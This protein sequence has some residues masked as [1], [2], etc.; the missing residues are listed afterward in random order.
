MKQQQING[1]DECLLSHHL[2]SQGIP[3]VV[4]IFQY[5]FLR[6]RSRQNLIFQ[7]NKKRNWLSADRRIALS[8]QLIN[9]H[10]RVVLPRRFD[11]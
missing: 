2:I 1:D 10:V 4:L 6:N 8:Y 9:Q 3:L 5:H 11:C 7:S